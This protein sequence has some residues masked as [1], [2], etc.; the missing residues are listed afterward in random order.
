MNFSK[1]I[2]I[3]KYDKQKNLFT[4]KNLRL[5]EEGKLIFCLE[6]TKTYRLKFDDIVFIIKINF[7]YT[8]SQRLSNLQLISDLQNFPIP[9]N[10]KKEF[11]LPINN[12]LYITALL[13][14]NNLY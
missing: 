11:I 14:E 4:L 2:K 3:L 5:R 13:F 12:L 8:N 10:K 7:E 6:E 1:K 9:S